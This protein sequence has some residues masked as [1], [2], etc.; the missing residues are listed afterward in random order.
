[1]SVDL[2]ELMRERSAAAETAV[3]TDRVIAVRRRIQL[4]RRRR[5]AG[6]VAAAV[7]VL[8]ALAVGATLLPGRPAPA[9]EPATTTRT[10]DGF[11]EY[12]FGAQVIGTG[13][14]ELP[15][16]QVSVTVVPDTLDLVFATR[17]DTPMWIEVRVAGAEHFAG[18]SCDANGGGGV[19][20]PVNDPAAS[21]EYGLAPGQP[22]T[23]TATV[24]H[25]I[26]SGVDVLPLP[27][28]G[29]FAV[30]VMRRVAFDEYPFPPVPATLPPIDDHLPTDAAFALRSDRDDPLRPVSGTLAWSSGLQLRIISQAPGY[31]H[32][33][34]NGTS[35]GTHEN[36]GYGIAE[37]VFRLGDEHL[38]QFAEGTLV[39]VTAEPDRV[40][41]AWA[42]WSLP[43]MGAEAPVPT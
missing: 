22:A 17:C 1:M 26:G 6:T 33:F 4:V 3:R 18:M 38:A 41:G 13:V 27:E 37:T 11:P 5:A 25:A 8:A 32:L 19:W 43:A 36:W 7:A 39:T 35:V 28:R 20:G 12:Q 34:L 14:A 2:S 29:S 30:A 10:F 23:F 42:V 21:E 24:T 15:E 9:P 16:T 31:I 40:T